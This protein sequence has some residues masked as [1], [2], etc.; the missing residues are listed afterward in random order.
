MARRVDDAEAQSVDVEL[1]A[2]IDAQGDDVGLALLSHDGDAVRAI[3]KRRQSSDV[4]GVEMR[5]DGFD[6]TKVELV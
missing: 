2:I 3:T 6:E 1:V 4:V 5:I